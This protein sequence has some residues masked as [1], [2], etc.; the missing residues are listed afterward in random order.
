VTVAPLV[1]PEVKMVVTAHKRAFSGSRLSG[2]M[3]QAKA[4]ESYLVQR[5]DRPKTA[6]RPQFRWTVS[7]AD[8]RLVRV[9]R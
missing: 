1:A 3:P 4:T 6:H 7:K 9:W 8:G 5:A 2:E